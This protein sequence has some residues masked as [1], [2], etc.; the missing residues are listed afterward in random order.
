MLLSYEPI[1]TLKVSFLCDNYETTFHFHA[2]SQILE[3]CGWG[4]W[5]LEGSVLK[6]AHF[7][8]YEAFSLKTNKQKTVLRRGKRWEIKTCNMLKRVWGF[9]Q[10]WRVSQYIPSMKVHISVGEKQAMCLG[11][12]YPETHVRTS[13]VLNWLLWGFPTCSTW[14]YIP[15]FKA[16]HHVF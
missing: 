12:M 10:K 3:I 14:G 16:K 15:H 1:S 5:A 7:K 9:L 4:I 2:S 11:T 13:L 8:H 6:T